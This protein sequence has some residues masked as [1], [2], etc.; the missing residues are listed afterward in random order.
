LYRKDITN[1]NHLIKNKDNFNIPV[2][3]NTKKPANI[4]VWAYSKSKGWAERLDIVI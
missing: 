3:S 1:L 2:E 4:V